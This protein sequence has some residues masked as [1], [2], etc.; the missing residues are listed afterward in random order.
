LCKYQIST[1]RLSLS[2]K[3]EKY[4]KM[5]PYENFIKTQEVVLTEYGAVVKW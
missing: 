1:Y 4:A 2:I 3:D 5:L